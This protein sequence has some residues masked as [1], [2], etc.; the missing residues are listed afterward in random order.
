[1]RRATTEGSS[2]CGGEACASQVGSRSPRKPI[3]ESERRC[4]TAQMSATR[5]PASLFDEWGA[6]NT[7]HYILA[8]IL[9]RRAFVPAY[10][11][12]VKMDAKTQ[13]AVGLREVL[14]LVV[15]GGAYNYL[16][17]VYGLE[18]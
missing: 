4:S 12:E 15:L 10:T 7:G 17:L 16:L 1:M 9:A 6:A 18:Y 8:Y 5:L 2:G 13:Q 11:D 14:V 3:R